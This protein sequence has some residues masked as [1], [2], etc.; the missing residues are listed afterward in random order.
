MEFLKDYNV[1]NIE[2]WKEIADGMSLYQPLHIIKRSDR[3]TEY[4]S[5]TIEHGRIEHTITTRFGGVEGI[6]LTVND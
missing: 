3:Y 4:F 6:K 2:K 5:V 1:T